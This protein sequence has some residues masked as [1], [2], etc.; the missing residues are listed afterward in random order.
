M[1]RLIKRMPAPCQLNP[2]AWFP[3]GATGQ[4]ALGQM[5]SAAAVCN[6]TCTIRAT[7]LA[8]A[9]RAE[10]TAD[11]KNRHGVFGGLTPTERA[12]LAERRRQAVARAVEQALAA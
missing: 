2:D 7:C 4:V 9:M 12:K 10:G 8:V 11:G 1:N 5:K 6:S 3:E